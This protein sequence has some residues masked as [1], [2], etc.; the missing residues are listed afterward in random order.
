M[1]VDSRTV[2]ADVTALGGSALR[3]ELWFAD[4]DNVES[5]RV[6]LYFNSIGELQRLADDIVRLA[7]ECNR[8]YNKK[9]DRL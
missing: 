4:D 8:K 9:T 3:V 2:V 6:S 7:Q 1:D 5:N